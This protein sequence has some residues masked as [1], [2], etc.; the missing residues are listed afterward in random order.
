[1]VNDRNYK[2]FLF[3]HFLKEY[4]AGRTPNPDTL[5][6]KEIKFNVFLHYALELGAGRI[7]TGHY[8]RIEKNN[9]TW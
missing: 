1:M 7:A 5:C 9:G 8:A 3:D 2:N 6:N 4:A